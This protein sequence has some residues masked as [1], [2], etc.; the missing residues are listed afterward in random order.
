[1]EH[2]KGAGI[3]LFLALLLYIAWTDYKTRRIPDKY[4]VALLL[5][6]IL[7]A[8][9]YPALSMPDRMAGGAVVSG[10]LLVLSLIRPGSFGGGDIKLMAA[11]GFLT[12]LNLNI[13]AFVLA[14]LTAGIYVCP[15]RPS[16]LSANRKSGKHSFAFGP[17]L[18]VGIIASILF[19]N[20][21]TDWFLYK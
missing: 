10:I 18:C 11:T 20:Y 13:W 15:K 6:G 12:G 9:F 8:G 5:W 14:V 17:F 4:T 16:P 3:I 7:W 1:M 2:L 21:L 19:G